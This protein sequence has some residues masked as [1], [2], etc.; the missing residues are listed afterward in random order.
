VPLPPVTPL[1][2]AAPIVRRKVNRPTPPAIPAARSVMSAAPALP[3]PV[4]PSRLV[5]P[6]TL[7]AQFV[8]SEILKPPVSMRTPPF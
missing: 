8:L 6:E 5:R 3:A 1:P 7:R 2:A 4:S